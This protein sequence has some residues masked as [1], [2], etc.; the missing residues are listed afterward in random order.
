MS[1]KGAFAVKGKWAGNAVKEGKAEEGA[2]AEWELRPCG[3][4]VQKRDPD[5]EAAHAG[6]LI[7]VKVSFG[8]TSHRVS[9]NA[10]STFGDLKKLLVQVTGLQTE[11]QRLLYKGK[12]KSDRDYL[13]EAGIKDKSKV[14]LVED[15]KGWEKRLVEMRKNDADAKACKAVAEVQQLVDQM[16]G[17]IAALEAAIATGKKLSDSDLVGPSDLLMCQLIKLDDSKVD[18]DAKVQK[19][20]LIRRVQKYVETLDALKLRNDSL[21]V[22]NGSPKVHEVHANGSPKVHEVHANG[23]VDASSPQ[24]KA[25]SVRT[26]PKKFRTNMPVSQNSTVVTTTWETFGSST[27]SVHAKSA[28]PPTSEPLL[29]QWD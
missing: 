25:V 12:Y 27:G 19:R 21:R 3:M 16:S 23:R 20:I 13:S 8:R 15:T 1:F 6:P 5:A 14:V 10:H 28:P 2:S 11:Q 7:R 4:L 17:Q 9:V 26:D 29:I 18:G 24:K 22:Q